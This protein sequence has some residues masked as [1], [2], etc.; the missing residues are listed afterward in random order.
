MLLYSCCVR[1]VSSTRSGM[2]K[3]LYVK[4]KAMSLEQAICNDKTH[5]ITIPIH[6]PVV[7]ADSIMDCL[8]EH[9]GEDNCTIYHLDIAPIV[10]HV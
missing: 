8:K 5:I 6:G 9:I 2:G 1:V 10:S 4:R 7:S 3:S